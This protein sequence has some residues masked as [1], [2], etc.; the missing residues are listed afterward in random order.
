MS[1]AE[2]VSRVLEAGRR[3]EVV[4]EDAPPGAVEQW[5]ALVEDLLRK[6]VLR[7]PNDYKGGKP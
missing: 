1:T 7:L 5:Q 6:H 4:R 3:L 2:F